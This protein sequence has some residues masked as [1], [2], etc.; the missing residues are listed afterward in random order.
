MDDENIK[1]RLKKI[2]TLLIKCLNQ[3][4]NKNV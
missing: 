2:D 4:N 3:N 1:I